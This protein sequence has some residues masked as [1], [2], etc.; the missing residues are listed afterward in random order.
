MFFD[1]FQSLW[2][3]AYRLFQPRDALRLM[4]CLGFVL[5]VMPVAEI[6]E[7]LNAVL[8]PHLE[9]MQQLATVQVCL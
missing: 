1:A 8:T 5:S 7:Y 3:N 4:A 9:L 2:I 6:M